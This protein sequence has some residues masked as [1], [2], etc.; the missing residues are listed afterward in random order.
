MRIPGATYRLQFGEEFGFDEARALVPYLFELGITDLYASPLL[1][2]REGT[3]GYHVTDPTRLDPS[4]GT[5]QDFDRLVAELRRHDM[6][7]L[8]DFVPNH[9]AASSENPW[10]MDVLK[11]GRRSRFA[12]FFDIDWDAG[13]DRVI[14]PVLAAPLEDIL[15]SGELKLDTSAREPTVRYRDHT[16]PIAPGSYFYAIGMGELLE[17]QHYRLVHWREAGRRINYRRFFDISDLVGLR[18]EDREVFAATHAL[19][20]DLVREGAVTGLRVDHVDG[21]R[22]PLLYLRRLQDTVT[23]SIGA[24]LYVLVEKILGEEETLP[25]DW[26]VAGT[27]GYEFISA[28]TGLFTD[29]RGLAR[30]RRLSRRRESPSRFRDLAV[31][32]KRQV[33]D[34]LFGGEMRAL[35]ARLATLAGGEEGID[36]GACG[37]VIAALTAELPVYRTYIRAPRVGAQDR[38]YIETASAGAMRR[39]RRRKWPALSFLRRVLLLDGPADPDAW[40]DF[41][42]R[43]QQFTGPVAA[44]GV[45]DSALY[46]DPAFLARNEVGCEPGERPAS[47]DDFHAFNA[48]RQKRFRHGLS[49]TSTHDTKRSEDVRTRIAVLSE[50]PDRWADHVDTWRRWNASLRDEVGGNRAPDD[51]DELYLYETFVGLWGAPGEDGKDLVRRLQLHATKAIREARIHTSWIDPDPGY[52]HAV[53]AFV[54][55]A[56]S[57]SPAR[58][59]RDLTRFAAEVAAPAAIQSLS[60]VLLK[61]AAPGV[62]DFYQGTE[63]WNLRLVDPDNRRPVDFRHRVASLERLARGSDPREFL[64]DVHGAKT[65]LLV[66]A[67]AL[68]V[69]REHAEL[70][71]EGAYVPLEVHGPR[72]SHVVAFARRR[73][74]EWAIAVA[75]RL[76]AGIAG[77]KRPPVGSMW[78]G[79]RIFLPPAAPRAWVDALCGSEVRAAHGKLDLTDVLGRFPVALLRKKRDS[80]D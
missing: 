34:E 13:Q 46:A 1:A 7:L 42:L 48:A 12:R 67:R 55:A 32:K 60:Q 27:T 3:S 4:L 52:E 44:K 30:L 70:F 66:T 18:V 33:I 15:G 56:L 29:P 14:V 76:V 11:Q 54:R 75:P 38:A 21:L 63:L 57:S 31:E 71:A 35:S 16:F 49:S 41:V 65:K 19:V 28:V 37:E 10:W 80:Q 5:R 43:W 17:H 79:T 53:G 6:G 25:A 50:I 39:A 68:R 20:F 78:E 23:A 61:I 22:D 45:E 62:P 47:V 9:M 77:P 64:R 8:L 59:R 40:L 72:A 69:R 2:A 74:S 36:Q 51:D 24:P 73:R 26:P 58:F